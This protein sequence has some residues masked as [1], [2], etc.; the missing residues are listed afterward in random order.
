MLGVGEVRIKVARSVRPRIGTVKRPILLTQ[1]GQLGTHRLHQT[2]LRRREESCIDFLVLNRLHDATATELLRQLEA[3]LPPRM[4]SS[5]TNKSAPHPHALSSNTAHERSPRTPT[6]C[7]SSTAATMPVRSL[8]PQGQRTRL[9]SSSPAELFRRWASWVFITQRA[10]SFVVDQSGTHLLP[11]VR[12]TQ[13]SGHRRRG[14]QFSGCRRR[15]RVADARP[16]KPRASAISSPG[17]TV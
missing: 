3:S 8:H 14:R 6:A 9:P 4:P 17:V 5:S 16:R 11:A 15:P 10:G 1:S 13:P 12:V 7:S 2:H